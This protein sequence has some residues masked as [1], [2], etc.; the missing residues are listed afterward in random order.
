L[1]QKPTY[2]GRDTNKVL[3]EPRMRVSRDQ[4]RDGEQFLEPTLQL[5]T[6]MDEDPR[7]SVLS[8]PYIPPTAAQKGKSRATMTSSTGTQT[9]VSADQIDN[10]LNDRRKSMS[11]QAPP[12]MVIGVPGASKVPN[13]AR[14]MSLGSVNGRPDAAAFLQ[15]TSRPSSSGSSRR[16]TSPPPGQM[17]PLPADHREVI[18]AAARGTG[19][20]NMPPPNLMPPPPNMMM[21]PPN[22]AGQPVPPSA[23]RPPSA[24][25]QRAPSGTFAH[26]P[27]RQPTT[28]RHSSQVRSEY[29]T[30]GTRRSSVS[31]FQ[32]E[33]DERFGMTPRHYMG[34]D[35]FEIAPNTDPRMIQAITQTMI[36]EFLWKYT[37]KAGRS[38]EHSENRHKRFFWI[39]PYTRTLYWSNQDPSL[40]S[41]KELKAKSVAIEAVRVISDENAIPAGLHTKSL[42]VVTPGRS[43][44]FTAPTIQRHETWF[45]ALSY[46]LLRKDPAAADETNAAVHGS[47]PSKSLS[48]PYHADTMNSSN[49]TVED[50]AEFN[51]TYSGRSASAS[52]MTNS[53][54][55]SLG[56]SVPATQR[57]TQQSTLGARTASPQRSTPQ[58]ASLAARQSSATRLVK[59]QPG[60]MGPPV[61]NM[62]P[63]VMN[64]ASV[65]SNTTNSIA[66]HRPISS[67]GMRYLSTNAPSTPGNVPTQS[68]LE[69]SPAKSTYAAFQGRDGAADTASSRDGDDGYKPPLA[70]TMPTGTARESRNSRLGSMTG[71]WRASLFGRGRSKSRGRTGAPDEPGQFGTSSVN[72]ASGYAGSRSSVGS[73]G[74]VDG[75]GD[76]PVPPLPSGGWGQGQFVGGVENVRACCDGKFFFSCCD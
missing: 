71:G 70:T 40:P 43:I 63:P 45:N 49:Y 74:Q 59:Q 37:R 15:N 8:L 9:L 47:T 60:I 73:R 13:E 31:S 39:H 23:W 24:S 5:P 58:Q 17:P 27:S 69:I 28:P 51:P 75:A 2:D 30:P 18:A 35:G 57:S 32:S 41:Q 64:Y 48:T 61:N 3:L 62:G 1:E 26:S 72:G 68:T 34:G 52:R 55:R 10:L 22:T 67:G 66:E 33:L 7:K 42:V 53:S 25:R 76:V 21:P 65:S 14:T 56:S 11:N 29:G 36:G 6:P 16:G 54:R 19:P 44:K 50:I 20:T 46:L 12:P 38:G 4:A